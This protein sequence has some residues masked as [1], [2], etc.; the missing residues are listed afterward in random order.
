MPLEKTFFAA[1]HFR[2]IIYT[3]GGYN[4]FEKTQLSDC[5][6]YDTKLDKWFNDKGRS[7]KLH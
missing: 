7:F 4:A 3:F 2:G 6:Y 1:V 5:S